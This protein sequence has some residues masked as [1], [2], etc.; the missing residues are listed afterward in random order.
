MADSGD[1]PPIGTS[2]KRLTIVLS[3]L[4][5]F[6]SLALGIVWWD[7]TTYFTRVESGSYGFT[8]AASTI[9]FDSSGISIISDQIHCGRGFLE[10]LWYKNETIFPAPSG[11]NEFGNVAVII[12]IYL[13]ILAYISSLLLIWLV[14][15]NRLA[16]HG[17]LWRRGLHPLGG[18]QGNR[19]SNQRA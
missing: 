12:P 6:G 19:S 13:L 17:S 5:L 16:R 15:M 2:Q 18:G 4:A 11:Y 1:H 3:S 14:L 7:S 9:T 10:T 8:V